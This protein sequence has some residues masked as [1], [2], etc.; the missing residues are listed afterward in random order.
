MSLSETQLMREHPGPVPHPVALVGEPLS[1]KIFWLEC[2]LS[3]CGLWKA[4]HVRNEMLIGKGLEYLI[5]AEYWL[6]SC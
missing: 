3:S 5:I 1:K 4:E 6:I 2:P